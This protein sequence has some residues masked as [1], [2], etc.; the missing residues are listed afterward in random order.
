[1]EKRAQAGES[2]RLAVGRMLGGAR[3]RLLHDELACTRNVRRGGFRR[4]VRAGTG[5]AW[6]S[7]CWSGW[8]ADYDER[9]L[10]IV[11]T[12]PTMIVARPL[13]ALLQ[14]GLALLAILALGSIAGSAHGVRHVAADVLHTAWISCTRS[15]GFREWTS[16]TGE[17]PGIRYA[18]AE[19]QSVAKE[20]AGIQWNPLHKAAK[21]TRQ[22]HWYRSKTS[23]NRGRRLHL[24]SC[25]WS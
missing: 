15:A 8:C 5:V 14:I 4:T 11:R 3:H 25:H 21:Q 2:L 12:T 9:P 6:P 17:Q 20:K 18:K 24:H 19:R 22:N 16:M 13:C 1:M 23:Q 10:W 7:P